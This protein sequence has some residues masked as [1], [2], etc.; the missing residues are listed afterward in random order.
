M[1]RVIV[2][3]VSG[4]AA[5]CEPTITDPCPGQRT[6]PNS[7]CCDV[8]F[9]Y[10]CGTSCFPQ[11]CGSGQVTCVNVDRTDGCYGGTWSG[12]YSGTYTP[13]G[14]GG[15]PVTGALR[16]DISN[17]VIVV[18]EPSSATGTIDCESGVGTWTASGSMPLVFRG[19]WMHTESNGDKISDATISLT[20]SDGS[21]TGTWDAVRIE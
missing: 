8:G 1:R 14:G 3:M 10:Q 19:T 9:P 5:G 18:S 2:M 21:A 7:V 13:T 11:P 12:S 4:F 16:F 20:N 6:C 17:A 15:Q